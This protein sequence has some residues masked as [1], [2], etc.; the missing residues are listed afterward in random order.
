MSASR[1]FFL[2]FFF[3]FI[4]ASSSHNAYTCRIFVLY[5]TENLWQS[6]LNAL[7][8]F[9]FIFTVYIYI[10]KY[11]THNMHVLLLLLFQSYI[12]DSYT[13]LGDIYI[14]NRKQNNG[15]QWTLC[16]L[17]MCVGA[18]WSD[19]TYCC[20]STPNVYKQRTMQQM[21][22]DVHFCINFFLLFI[23][24]CVVALKFS[25]SRFLVSL[26]SDQPILFV[27]HDS[28]PIIL[29]FHCFLHQVTWMVQKTNTQSNSQ[30]H[31]LC[32]RKCG[33]NADKNM[34]KT[35]AKI[36]LVPTQPIPM[37]IWANTETRILS[38]TI[39]I[40]TKKQ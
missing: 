13:A 38:C 10:C 21:K 23:Y 11:N 19:V 30:H 6:S 26:H 16:I 28:T 33:T 24:F 35:S 40:H 27:C 39:P 20:E 31:T 37:H 7:S 18:K 9:H 1:I 25:F 2:C 22:Y 3:N 5:A 8:R 34:R 36:K 32:L 12:E 15:Q 4:L 17:L 14:S 29:T